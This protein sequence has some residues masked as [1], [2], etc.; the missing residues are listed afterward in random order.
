LTAKL[1]AG[2]EQHGRL[3]LGALR[4]HGRADDGRFG[5]ENPAVAPAE[6]APDASEPDSMWERPLPSFA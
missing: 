2:D 3:A 5:S 6:S 4:S 1:S